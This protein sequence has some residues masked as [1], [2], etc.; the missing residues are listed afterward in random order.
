MKNSNL[1]QAGIN[2]VFGFYTNLDHYNKRFFRSSL[3]IKQVEWA[4]N[5]YSKKTEL[6]VDSFEREIIR[7]IILVKFYSATNTEHNIA[8]YL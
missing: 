3:T 7:D 5:S 4:Y 2:Y 8:K 6:R 1:L